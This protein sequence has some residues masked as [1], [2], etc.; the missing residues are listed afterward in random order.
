MNI[1]CGFRGEKTLIST[2]KWSLKIQPDSTPAV[3][4]FWAEK[5]PPL[6][7]SEVRLPGVMRAER[8]VQQPPGAR[9]HY[10]QGADVGP[11]GHPAWES[12]SEL[13]RGGGGGRTRI[14]LHA[15]NRI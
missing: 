2:N 6:I 11:Q 4:P 7:P 12:L 13:V 10:H 15:H 9:G 8:W 14:Y 3:R 5:T 1:F